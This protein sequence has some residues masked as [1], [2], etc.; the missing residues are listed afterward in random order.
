MFNRG[1]ESRVGKTAAKIDK[2][3]SGF[4]KIVSDLETAQ[5]KFAEAVDEANVEIARLSNVVA[6][7]EDGIKR[8][9]KVKNNIKK[10]VS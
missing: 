8:T 7:A 4:N 1:V 3:L 10:L 5:E 6:A 9:E 2:V